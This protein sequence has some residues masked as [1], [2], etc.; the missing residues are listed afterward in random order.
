[1]SVLILNVRSCYWDLNKI[2]ASQ[3]VLANIRKP[4]SIGMCSTFLQLLHEDERTE[5]NKG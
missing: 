1:M 5:I 3:E 4:L 2:V